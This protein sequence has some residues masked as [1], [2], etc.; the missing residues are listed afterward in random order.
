MFDSMNLEL[1]IN[2]MYDAGV[3]DDSLVLLYR[4]FFFT[5]PP[6]NFLSPELAPPQ[7]KNFIQV[8]NWPPPNTNISS[9]S[10]TGPHPQHKVLEVCMPCSTCPK[11][12]GKK[13]AELA[14]SA[15]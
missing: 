3:K 1:A 15:K 13:H 5:R 6:L 12:A 4:V 7:Q 14:N 8:L 11:K 10:S 9:K 2:D